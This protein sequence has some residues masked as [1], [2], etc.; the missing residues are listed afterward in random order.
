M[1]G[2]LD[3]VHDKLVSVDF[4]HNPASSSFRTGPTKVMDGTLCLGDDLVR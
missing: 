1:K 2:I 3:V 4:N